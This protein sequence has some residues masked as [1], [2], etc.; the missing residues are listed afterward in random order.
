M[1]KLLL[2]EGFL[3]ILSTLIAI[4]MMGVI[5]FITVAILTKK[6]E[7]IKQKQR[8]K[9]RLFYIMSLFFI[10][11]LAQIWVKGFTQLITV[12]GIVSAALVVTNKETI[13]NF[14]GWLI[15]IWRGLFI[16]EDL[17]EVQ[18]FKGYVR[19]VRMLYFTLLEVDK[20]SSN[21][22][23]GRLIRIPNGLVVTNPIINFSTDHLI[24]QH[25]S[26]IVERNS[27]IEAGKTVVKMIMES[28]L[29][30][31]YKEKK[32]YTQSFLKKRNKKIAEMINLQPVIIIRLRYDDPSGIEIIARYYCY[33][34]DQE[35]IEQTV[36]QQLM[37]NLATSENIKLAI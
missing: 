21:I 17:I 26:I 27:D 37:E 28:A 11:I 1:Q 31:I 13:M 18:Q 30:S 22:I 8:R 9:I 3:N 20:S 29:N 15:I 32:E 19:S 35:L 16:E 24:E 34:A 33:P 4:I 14:V 6:N 7:D 10:F 23:T 12:L 5:Y 36:L 25:F 2:S